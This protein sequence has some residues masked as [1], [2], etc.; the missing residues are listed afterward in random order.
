MNILLFSLLASLW[1]GSFVAIKASLEAYPPF[2]SASLRVL[3]ASLAI[4]LLY[5]FLKID[6]QVAPRERWRCYGLGMFSIAIP[7]SLLFWGEQFVDAG[8]AGVIN[9]TTPIWTFLSAY[10]V[11]QTERSKPV[12]NA[13]GIL[14]SF[15]G[16]Y[17]I[18]SPKITG[19][20]HSQE[21]LGIAA[22][23]GMA[24]SYGV[25]GN[26]AKKILNSQNMSPKKAIYH[27]HLGAVVALSVLAMLFE[28]DQIRQLTQF[29]LKSSL[30]LLYLGIFSTAI[31]YL[32]L[33]HLLAH[34]GPIKAM[35]VTYLIPI[36]ALLFDYL[37]HAHRLQD[38]QLLGVMSVLVGLAI[39]QLPAVELIR[40]KFNHLRQNPLKKI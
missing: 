6:T 28:I 26:L 40:A 13:L 35:S 27:Q 39:L 2:F 31:A 22:I 3:I 32:I 12:Q 25:G 8:I 36:M 20:T 16:I 1:G 34:W 29:P 18:F 11:F 33:F 19:S 9:G 21:W 4:H 30:A 23:F 10:Y 24:I 7:F 15:I 14:V 38:I 37:L 17:L 5:K